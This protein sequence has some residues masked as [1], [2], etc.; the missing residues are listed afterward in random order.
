MNTGVGRQG[1][2]VRN[3]ALKPVTNR[4]RLAAKID[5]EEMRVLGAR[6]STHL[7]A[8]LEH[9]R[10]TMVHYLC[11]GVVLAEAK[12]RVQHGEWLAW[13]RKYGGGL[14][15]DSAQRYLQVPRY[16]AQVDAAKYRAV[17]F[18]IEE[19]GHQITPAVADRIAS[20]TPELEGRTFRNIGVELKAIK[21]VRQQRRDAADAHTKATE[22][23]SDAQRHTQAAHALWLKVKAQLALLAPL[24]GAFESADFNDCVTVL[25]QM[26]HGLKGEVSHGDTEAQR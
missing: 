22:Q 25:E 7:L 19:A 1:S 20:Q 9:G 4:A 15:A 23:L 16:L 26:L 11:V 17:R 21:T 24:T 10:R 3:Q 6:L 8:F 13:L 18:L 14:S 12:A 5:T 2:G